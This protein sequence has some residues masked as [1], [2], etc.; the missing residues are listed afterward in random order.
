M[1]YVEEH[2]TMSTL[3]YA[4]KQ[5]VELRQEASRHFD[6]REY[7]ECQTALNVA[8]QYW[9]NMLPREQKQ[10]AAILGIRP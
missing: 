2:A 5:Y 6:S 10:A 8:A 7:Q 9:R 1:L 3:P 4:V